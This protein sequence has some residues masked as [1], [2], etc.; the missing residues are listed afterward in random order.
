MFFT[1]RMLVLLLAQWFGVCQISN[2]SGNW[3]RGWHCSILPSYRLWNSRSLPLSV[4]AKVTVICRLSPAPAIST[5]VLPCSAWVHWEDSTTW[6]HSG[7]VPIYHKLWGDFSVLDCFLDL[8]KVSFLDSSNFFLGKNCPCL[9][10]CLSLH[11]AHPFEKWVG[12]VKESLM[13]PLFSNSKVPSVA[14]TI[15]S[16]AAITTLAFAGVPAF[17]SALVDCCTFSSRFPRARGLPLFFFASWVIS[18]S[19][20]NF[21]QICL[22]LFL[23]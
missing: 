9:S 7:L 15:P 10:G 16:A 12:P 3:V 4:P 2:I 21:L 8:L 22:I 19:D 6:I 1:K 18:S 11:I 17:L 5:L 14:V 20:S 23:E 13:C